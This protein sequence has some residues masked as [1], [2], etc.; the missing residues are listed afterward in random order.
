MQIMKLKCLYILNLDSYWS[1]VCCVSIVSGD[2]GP[3]LYDTLTDGSW[4]QEVWKRLDLLSSICS[5]WYSFIFVLH[6]DACSYMILPIGAFYG[7]MLSP[8]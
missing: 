5:A 1:S 7:S 4:K 3:S 8:W 6:M 2:Y